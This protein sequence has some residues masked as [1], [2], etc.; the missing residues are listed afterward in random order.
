MSASRSENTQTI[1]TTASLQP[2]VLFLV[3]L[4]AGLLVVIPLLPIWIPNMLYSFSGQAP[5]VYWYL[6]RAAG[7]VALTIL[8]VAMALGLGI[9]NKMARMWP[10]APAAF[11]IHE[12]VSLLGVAFALYHALVLIGDHF[13]DFS[14][15][16]LMT[17][18]SIAYKTFWIGLGQL[19][20]YFWVIVVLSFYVRKFIG[21][22]VWRAIH[23]VNFATYLMGISHGIFSGTDSGAGWAQWYYILSVSSLLVLAGYRVIEAKLK[24]LPQPAARKRPQ[25]ASPHTVASTH[26][27]TIPTTVGNLVRQTATAQQTPLSANV[28]NGELLIKATLAR[29]VSEPVSQVTLGEQ[30][31]QQQEQAVIL[32]AV[33][34]EA[35]ALLSLAPADMITVAEMATP[36]TYLPGNPSPDPMEMDVQLRQEPVP[37]RPEWPSASQHRQPATTRIS[38]SEPTLPIPILRMQIKRAMQSIAVQPPHPKGLQ[39]KF[40]KEMA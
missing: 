40:N 31:D 39:T 9:T 38:S 4:V 28:A 3:A 2:F 19:G 17:P 34:M 18:F 36:L 20:F 11:A 15:P 13:T 24:H 7:F 37:A 16:R 29:P 10:G 32:S 8:W 25:K 12:Y 21:P 5:K 23:Y 6:S 35:P 22:K 33:T 14:L 1:E 30:T 26:V 27:P